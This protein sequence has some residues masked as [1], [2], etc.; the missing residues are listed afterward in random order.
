MSAQENRTFDG[1]LRPFPAFRAAILDPKL[2]TKGLT[3]DE[4]SKV[5]GHLF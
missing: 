3:F 5:R 1:H 4:I 2:R